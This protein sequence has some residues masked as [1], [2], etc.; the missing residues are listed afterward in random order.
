MTTDVATLE[1]QASTLSQT[2]EALQVTDPA[3]FQEAGELVKTVA[4]YIRRVGEVLDPIVEAAH[5]AHKIAVQQ[6]DT[7]LK[8]AQRARAVLGERMAT[9][10][11]AEARRRREAE[12]AAQRERER[13]E[14][15]AREQ[16]EAETRRLQAEAETR[17]IDEAAQLES[18]GD[19][20]G[21]ARLIAAPVSAPVVMPAPVF[22]PAP[23]IAAPPKVE[24]VS[25]RSTWK[26]RLVDA[27]QLPRQYLIPDDKA[28]GAVVRA[29]GPRTSIPGITVY[30]ERISSVRPA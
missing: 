17:R 13:L 6:R 8:P 21:A 11:Q 15:E 12:Q 4:L 3:T 9:Y 18:T 26:W 20:E 19:H 27:A 23:P 22:Q 2:V 30:E 29:M 16:A 10:E 7:L 5:R 24:G 1:Q 28:I 25:F 14:R